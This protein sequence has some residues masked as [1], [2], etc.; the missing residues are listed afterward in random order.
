[1]HAYVV[2]RNHVNWSMK[3]RSWSSEN[4]WISYSHENNKIVWLSNGRCILWKIH[5][6]HKGLWAFFL[7]WLFGCCWAGKVRSHGNFQT[8]KDCCTNV[9]RFIQYC[10]D[11]KAYKGCDFKPEDEDDDLVKRFARVHLDSMEA[12]NKL[13]EEEMTGAQMQE[14]QEWHRQDNWVLALLKCILILQVTLPHV[15]TCFISWL[16]FYF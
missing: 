4:T 16:L 7:D 11:N 2:C 13:R 12:F 14:E 1:M 8:L 5:E 9:T 10:I 3:C 15:S 6:V